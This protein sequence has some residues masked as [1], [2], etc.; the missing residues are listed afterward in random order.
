MRMI[1]GAILLLAAEQAFA[2]AYLVG[3]P[4]Q[5]FVSQVLTPGSLLLGVIGLVFLIWGL[6]TDHRK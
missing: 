1:T 5:A 4:H 2:H 6:I 3:F